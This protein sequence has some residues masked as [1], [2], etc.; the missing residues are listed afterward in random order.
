MPG[1]GASHRR[2]RGEY[3]GTD[4]LQ[5]VLDRRPGSGSLAR[6]AL[7]RDETVRNW[8]VITPSATVIG[9]PER[10][11]ADLPDRLRRLHD[12]R[13]PATEGYAERA[14]HLDRL[15]TTQALCNVLELTPWQRDLAL[16]VMDD[17]DLTEFGSQRAIGTVALVVI[18]HVVDLDR[19]RYFGLEDLDVG[20]LSPERMETL[21]A[22]YR[23][24]DI[25]DDPTFR[26]LAAEAGLDTTSLNRLRRVLTAQLEAGIR[27]YGRDRH[28][29][30][31]IPRAAPNS[32]RATD[33]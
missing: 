6:A 20:S 18:R 29:D 5:P 25:T 16:G 12:E 23:A 11:D 30:P 19:R 26:R 9:R 31:A 17:L 21:F 15:R 7:Q 13:H 27:P 8:G 4:R 22:E 24:H 28:R 14:H 1:E 10:P 2:A 33:E 32:P 3:V